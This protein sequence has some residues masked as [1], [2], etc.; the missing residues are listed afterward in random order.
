MRGAD[1]SQRTCTETVL[2]AIREEIVSGR[3]P[4]ASKLNLEPYS[5]KFNVSQPVMRK[6]AGR[7]SEHRLLKANPQQGF[8]ILPPSIEDL[9]ALA[10]ARVRGN[11]RSA[12]IDRKWGPVLGNRRRCPHRLTRHIGVR[13]TR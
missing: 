13:R 3:P 10:R 8:N 6:V 2:D 7:L 5:K 1:S 9:T 4:A 12:R 11:G